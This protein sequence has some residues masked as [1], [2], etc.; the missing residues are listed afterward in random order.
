M[1]NCS[2]NTMKDV[3]KKKRDMQAIKPPKTRSTL[4]MFACA[5]KFPK[6]SK[7]PFVF[8][9]LSQSMY[10]SRQQDLCPQCIQAIIRTHLSF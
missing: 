9:T 6:P 8:L 10:N 4:L 1:L 7:W 2:Y 3:P 5:L